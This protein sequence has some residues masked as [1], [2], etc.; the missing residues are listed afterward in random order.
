M[1]IFEEE[2]EEEEEEKINKFRAG[3]AWGHHPILTPLNEHRTYNYFTYIG[4][5]YHY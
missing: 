2:E 4:T 1:G 5:V 3:R